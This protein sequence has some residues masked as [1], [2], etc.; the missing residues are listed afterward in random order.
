MNHGAWELL[1]MIPHISI[2][3]CLQPKV[4]PFCQLWSERTACPLDSGLISR[5]ARTLSDSKSLRE[6]ISPVCFCQLAAAPIRR[7]RKRGG[8]RRYLWRSCK[9]CRLRTREM[10]TPSS[11][12]DYSGNEYTNPHGSTS[13]VHIATVDGIYARKFESYGGKCKV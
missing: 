13:V 2:Y 11:K 1:T 7:D 5:N 12:P 3:S 6:G 4:S 10:L 9:R 8:N